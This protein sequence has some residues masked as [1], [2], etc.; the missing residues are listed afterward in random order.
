MAYACTTDVG[1][2]QDVISD[3]L[4]SE[5]MLRVLSA[6]LEHAV[7]Y[8]VIASRKVEG[9]IP[10]EITRIFI[11]PILSSSNMALRSTQPLIEMSTRNL[12]EGKWRQAPNLT[13][14]RLCL[15]NVGTSTSHN[16]MGLHRRLHR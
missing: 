4:V 9:S 13:A 5:S 15:E 14:D 11:L 10:D 1:L 2:Y 7:T 6:I 3:Y 12:F 16:H 8:M